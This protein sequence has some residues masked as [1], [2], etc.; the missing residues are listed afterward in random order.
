MQATP[1]WGGLDYVIPYLVSLP[2][3]A[4]LP[5]FAKNFLCN[6]APVPQAG[7]VIHLIYAILVAVPVSVVAFLGLAS[8][9]ALN[10]VEGKLTAKIPVKLRQIQQ[11]EFPWQ[12]ADWLPVAGSAAIAALVL[13]TI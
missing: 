3:A 13:L 5:L 11:C 8:F 6:Y 1:F 2:A 12:Q 10:R 7:Y 4:V 9:G